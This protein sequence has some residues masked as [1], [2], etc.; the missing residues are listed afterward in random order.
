MMLS[1]KMYFHCPCKRAL[2]I[3]IEHQG[4]RPCGIAVSSLHLQCA[5]QLAYDGVVQ[6]SP[7]D[8]VL[9]V[10]NLW[11]H[12]WQSELPLRHKTDVTCRQSSNSDESRNLHSLSGRFPHPIL[13]CAAASPLSSQA[14]MSSRAASKAFARASLPSCTSG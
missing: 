7:A 3:V 4:I 8:L 9:L 11:H 10:W 6:G 5:L 14:S 12:K 13:S 1:M 2:Y